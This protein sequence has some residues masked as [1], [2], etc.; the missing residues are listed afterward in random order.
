MHSMRYY[1]RSIVIILATAAAL[2]AALA[3]PAPT[4]AQQPPVDLSVG[5]EVSTTS[6]EI[7]FKASNDGVEDAF[8]VTVQ[9][10]LPDQVV[11]LHVSE[12]DSSTGVWHVGTL[13][14]GASA[15]GTLTTTMDPALADTY[16]KL[17]V[18]ARA[19]ISSDAPVEPPAL[20]HNN[21]AEAW[22]VVAKERNDRGAAGGFYSLKASVDNLL[23]EDADTVNLDLRMPLSSRSRHDST[24][25]GVKVRVQLPLGLDNPKVVSDSVGTFTA[26]RGQARTWEWDVGDTYR[27]RNLSL[28]IDVTGS[29]RLQGKCVTADLTVQR[30]ADDPSDN[31]VEVCFGDPPPTLFQTGKTDL[32]TLFP[33]VGSTTSPPCTTAGTLVVA[34]IGD[35][36]ALNAGIR[37][38]I[39]IMQPEDIVIQVKD[40]DGRVFDNHL[41]SVNGPND[42]SWQT[43]STWTNVQGVDI[44]L[45][46]SE[47]NDEYPDW[48]DVVRTMSARGLID[49]DAADQVC[50]S[51]DPS[52]PCAPGLM[53][54][55]FNSNRREFFDPNP[56]HTRPALTLKRDDRIPSP[57]FA[58]FEKL[59]T[60]VVEYTATATRSSTAILRPSESFTGTGTYTFHV[61]PIAELEVQDGGGVP[62]QLEPGQTAYSIVAVNNGPDA[63]SGA[64]VDVMLPEEAT[65]VRA[66]PSA[67][68]YKDNGNSGVWNVVGLR[69][70]G[71]YQATGRRLDGEDLTLIVNCPTNGCGTAGARIY[72]DNANHP[73]TVTIGNT[74]HEGTVYDHIDSNNTV[75]LEAL[76]GA[77]EVGGP[78]APQLM[79][80]STAAVVSWSPVEEVNGQPVS[81]Y[82]VQRS[83]SPWETVAPVVKETFYADTDVTPGQVYTYRVRAVNVP[84]VPGL[85]SHPMQATAP[86][87]AGVHVPGPPRDLA[88]AA[89]DGEI[90]A[91]WGEPE[92]LGNPRLNGYSV[93]YREQGA[94]LWT[95]VSRSGTGRSETITGLTNDTTYQV[96]VAAMNASGTGDYAEASGRPVAGAAVP[97]TPTDL[98]VTVEDGEMTLSWTAPESLGNPGLHGYLVQYRASGNWLTWTRTATDPLST[99]ETITGLDNGRT[100]QVRVAAVNTAG[101]SPYA[102]SS[103]RPVAAARTPGQPANL[104]L[105]PG[106]GRISAWWDEPA[107]VGV[108][109]YHTYLV[110]YSGDGGT[111]WTR[112]PHNSRGRT[113]TITGLDNGTEYLVWVA[114]VNTVG[115]GEYAEASATPKSAPTAVQCPAEA[116]IAHLPAPYNGCSVPLHLAPDDMQILVSWGE[117]ADN[118]GADITGFEVQYRTSGNWL[119]WNDNDRKYHIGLGALITDLDNGRRYQVRVRAVNAD[120][121]EGPWAQGSAVPNTPP[122]VPSEPPN[123]V[124]TGGD[125][126]IVVTWREPY[127]VGHP[128]LSG[129]RIQ[130]REDD[131]TDSVWLPASPASPFRVGSSARSY[132]I[133]GLKDGTTYQVQVWAVN[134]EGDSPKAG[135]DGALTATTDAAEPPDGDPAKGE[136]EPGS[137]PTA[138]RNLALTPGAT[139]IQVS[140]DAPE[141]LGN[142]EITG[143]TLEHRVVTDDGGG[144]WT[145]R[146]VTATSA[147]IEGLTTGETYEVQVRVSNANGDATAGPKRATPQD[148]PGPK[149]QNLA[150]VE[151]RSFVDV[152]GSTKKEFVVGWEPP[153]D[154]DDNE[155]S[156]FSGYKVQFRRGTSGDWLD[157]RCTVSDDPEP[158]EETCS[159]HR[160][161]RTSVAGIMGVS[162]GTYQVRVAA[163]YREGIGA[164]ATTDPSIQVR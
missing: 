61:G 144:S 76:P 147:T 103:G 111:T 154:S 31:S 101:A 81:H 41:D 14:G 26:V 91:S 130:Y 43:P 151:Q 3:V 27:T 54:I 117:P 4:Q 113:A 152:D 164:W 105:D 47:F 139:E 153:T 67:G 149:P 93:Q 51:G 36:A 34:A 44:T 75:E 94:Q 15:T 138:P 72:N 57:I 58:E 97:G 85:W 118:G 40:L 135:D 19:V 132:T 79:D 134:S 80:P 63:P 8:G 141:D 100:Y 28:E 129:Y 71:Y 29:E 86:P 35:T 9:I 20:L 22:A 23:P 56:T 131:G 104:V 114:A 48:E 82:E 37:S 156:D 160:G 110:E 46:L 108:P 125:K 124:P 120:G 107:D 116:A 87:S 115:A 128:A 74:R 109:T 65:L 146:K 96:R 17:A 52:P 7:T 42:V 68:T 121:R 66:I 6:G 13:K 55:R 32:F 137:A 1:S 140:W 16:D 143:Y 98:A 161:G 136:P 10:D 148:P 18:P 49:A 59:G 11:A 119:P 39:D 12:Y 155:R 38:V 25:Y 2:V 21:S 78:D 77:G 53:K 69:V 24:A 92:H 163:V 45:S 83:A 159:D 133:T 30:P 112:W 150:F 62:L 5:I 158:I 122:R 126:Q 73:Y 142:P 88:L 99:T 64:R 123:V 145:S 162:S 50:D 33:C 157:R 70:K 84:G 60:Y 90:T 102:T 106:N 127:D 95:P 89:G